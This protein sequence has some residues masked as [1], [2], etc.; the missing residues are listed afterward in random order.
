[1][2]ATEFANMTP[3]GQNRKEMAKLD[4]NKMK[5]FDLFKSI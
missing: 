1:M 5:G 2:H 4:V 3:K